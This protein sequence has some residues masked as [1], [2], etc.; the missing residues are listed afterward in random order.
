MWSDTHNKTNLSD[1]LENAA[2]GKHNSI[3]R[4]H[5]SSIKYFNFSIQAYDN[6]G[7]SFGVKRY[8]KYTWIAIKSTYTS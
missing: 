4:L 3:I 1:G 6:Q 8:A 2:G 5:L 7:F